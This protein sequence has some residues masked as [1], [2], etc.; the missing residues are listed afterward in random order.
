MSFS[1]AHTTRKSPPRLPYEDMKNEIL[2]TSYNLSLVFVGNYKSTQLNITHRK[3]SYTPNV[4]SFP[5]SKTE[6][7][8]FINPHKAQ[9]EA[10]QFDLSTRGYIGFLFIHALLHLKGYAHGDTMEEVE[11]RYIKRYSLS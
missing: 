3:K 7:E 9:K 2:G 6:G 5:L 11:A 1:L 4:L 10:P 8:V